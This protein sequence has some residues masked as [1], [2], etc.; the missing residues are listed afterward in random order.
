MD[1]G[2]DGVEDGLVNSE[3]WRLFQIAFD[4]VNFVLE[5]RLCLLENV[6]D[7]EIWI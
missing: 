3:S 2:V 6:E 7:L 5:F 1:D 4:D